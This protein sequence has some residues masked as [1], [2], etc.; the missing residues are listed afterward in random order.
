NGDLNLFREI[1][2]FQALVLCTFA[3]NLFYAKD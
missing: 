1:I 2:R 3:P